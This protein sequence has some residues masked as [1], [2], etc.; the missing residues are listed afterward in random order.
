[1]QLSVL[2]LLGLLFLTSCTTPAT[3]QG[4]GAGSSAPSA[5]KRMTVGVGTEPKGW[6]PWEAIT[7]VGGLEEVL[8]LATRTLTIVDGN[9]TVQPEL[10]TSVP[11][12]ASG[13]WKINSDGT[14]E[15]T[16]MLKPN[17][18]WHDGQAV[19]AEDFVFSWQV[20]AN[21]LLP[22]RPEDGFNLISGAQAVDLRTL[23]LT[24]R[25]ATP[26]AGQGIFNP[27][28]RHLLSL[29]MDSGDADRIMSSPYWNT[30]YVGAGPYRIVHWE[31]GAFVNY[32]AFSEYHGGKPKIDQLQV[33]FLSD[34]NTL[35]A[36]LL[37][38]EVDTTWPD[39]ISVEMAVDLQ[40]GWAAPGTGNNLMLYVDGRITRMTFQHR[41]EFAQ[42]SVALDPRVRRAFYHTMDK[43]AIN[44]VETGG[45]GALANSLVQPNDTRTPQFAS[46][47]PDWS[48]D[49]AL[50]QRVLADAGWQRG[51]DGTLV[52]GPTGQRMESDIRVTNTPGHVGALAI[53]ADGWRKIGAQVT[54]TVMPGAL[55]TNA[56][57]R[58]TYPWASLTSGT[59][60]SGTDGGVLGGND[61]SWECKPAL[62]Q[63]NWVGS[64]DGYCNEGVDG[65]VKRL[66]TTIPMA[67]RTALQMQ[68]LRALLMEEYATL[69]LFWLVV[70]LPYAKGITGPSP[71]VLGGVPWNIH[72]WDRP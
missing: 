46:V 55:S 54:E 10:A 16:W 13:D 45:A 6:G 23:R 33:K 63:N 19:T 43:D 11:S 30:E 62:R 2:G 35:L 20:W 21:P 22:N 42:P 18:K 47:V 26:L 64:R 41:Q 14:M 1:M 49:I 67:E 53:M 68:I 5:P 7:T 57:Y 36:N 59:G 12:V 32:E 66:Q 69:P 24:F 61:T 34:G 52:H 29:L 56:E 31:R 50:A 60:F 70:P 72:L 4:S 17:A 15:Q 37:A 27:Y 3:Q 25:T 40:R 48:L 71:A 39:G 9:R 8:P 58:S 38:G 65:L 44:L 51:P 28:P